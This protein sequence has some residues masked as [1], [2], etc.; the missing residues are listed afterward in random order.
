MAAPPI[1]ERHL[2]HFHRRS[3]IKESVRVATTANITI[4][5]ALNNGDTLDGITL[6]TDDRVLVKDQTAPAENGLYVVAASPARAYDQSTDDPAFG[7]L[8][9]VRQGTA[10]AQ[11][12]W[13]NTNTAAPTIGSTSIAFAQ[14]GGTT[15]AS[16]V[17]ITDAGGFY[18]ATD[19]E[20]ALQELARKDI[21]YT[22]HGNTGATETFDALTG[23]HSATLD[24]ATVT[25]TFTGATSGL[26]AAMVLELA[27]DG[28]GG[29]LVTWP[30]SVVWPGGVAPTL[31]TAA[32]AVDIL[33][34]FSRDG[35]TT[36]YGF[37]SGGGAVD[38]AEA[39]DLS[40]VGTTAAAGSSVETPRA[41]HV[42]ALTGATLTSLGAVGELLISDTPSTPLVF[43][44]LL[45]NEAQD[46]L[47]YADL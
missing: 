8:V 20:A 18:T 11:T 26:V 22:A 25:A 28:T 33:T 13:R 45:Q 9:F 31:S 15:V 17:S 37:A 24:A 41:D 21:G 44:D 2:H 34:F 27:Q 47:L 23:W 35:G 6:A 38:W 4:A 10:G 16:G 19:V 42:H 5:T 43:A 30:G 36:W 3:P 1:V 29:R 32:A 40:A 46:D 14:V 12:L 39:A 7:F